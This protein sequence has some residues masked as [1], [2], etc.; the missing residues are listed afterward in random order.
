MHSSRNIDFETENRDRQSERI[1][2][3][4]DAVICLDCIAFLSNTEYSS[5]CAAVRVYFHLLTSKA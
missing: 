4:N 2:L 5:W 1:A 3:C